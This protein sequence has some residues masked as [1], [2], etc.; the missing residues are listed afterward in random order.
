MT[1]A[2][3]RFS[4]VQ[5]VLRPVAE[6]RRLSAVV[7]AM[8]QEIERLHEDNVQLQAAVAMYR[9]V[10]RLYSS[11]LKRGTCQACFQAVSRASA[12]AAAARNPEA[13]Q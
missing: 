2:R 10:L 13:A 8:A 1:Q 5:S 12:G 3:A 4:E 11:K 7:K 6:S 9:E